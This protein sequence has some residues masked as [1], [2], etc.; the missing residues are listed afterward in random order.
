MFFARRLFP[1]SSLQRSFDADQPSLA[2]ILVALFRRFA[3]R[4]DAMPLGNLLRASPFPGRNWSVARLKFE[5]RVPPAVTRSSG[6]LPRRPI[7]ITLFILPMFSIHP[8]VSPTAGSLSQRGPPSLERTTRMS[9]RLLPIEPKNLAA[10]R[11]SLSAKSSAPRQE[12]HR[13]G[14]LLSSG[15]SDGAIPLR[16]IFADCLWLF[17]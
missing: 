12:I 17:A 13:R 9:D 7:R 1:G 14:S 6:S 10:W 5:T 2:Q 16:E 4:D 3:V 8:S 15:V 11:A